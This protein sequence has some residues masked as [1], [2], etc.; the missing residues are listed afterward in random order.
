MKSKREKFEDKIQLLRDTHGANWKNVCHLDLGGSKTPDP[1]PGQIAAAESATEV[2]KMQKETAME[3]LNFSKAQYQDFKDDLK[4]IAAAQKQIMSDSAKRAEEYATYERETFRPLEKRLVSEAE[5]FDTAAKREEM[6]SQGMAD[7]AQAYETQRQ[8]ALDTLAKYGVNPNSARFAAINAQLA[9]G[10]AGAR[11][12]VA[13]KSRVAAEEMGRARLYDA[14]A[15][16]RGLA[17][18]ATAAAGL[19]TS[20]GTSAGAT[21]LAPSEFMSKSYGQTGSMLG[22]AGSSYGT[23]GNIYGQEFNA[24]MGAYNAEQQRQAD[25]MSGIGQIAGSIIGG[26]GFFADGGKVKR[27]GR[28]GKVSGPG[29]PVD[30]RIPA[31]LSDGEYV[32]PADTVKAIG[33]K[34]LD[35]MVK[36]THTPAATQKRKALG[37]RSA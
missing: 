16:G 10:E 11:A 9:Q 1:N 17:S 12:G 30:D 23:A 29:G 2:G 21:T 6:A 36:Q 32:L 14:A 31:M 4:E 13:T 37:K 33:V 7:V 15:L 18:N 26:G 5:S 3:Y 20:A 8:Q 28:G 19:A 34:K 22:G 25:T 24:R 35:K 27:L